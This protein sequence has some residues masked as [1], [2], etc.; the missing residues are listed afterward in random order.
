M[1]N[2]NNKMFAWYE[3][4]SEAIGQLPSIKDKYQMML[5]ITEYG[6]Y[7][8]EPRFIDT[9][10]CPAFA[11]Q[12]IFEACRVNLDNSRTNYKKGYQGASAGIKGGRPRKGE[13]AEEAYA[14]RNGTPKTSEPDQAPAP[15][16]A[17][18]MENVDAILA[19]A[20]KAHEQ[21]MLAGVSY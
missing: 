20:T 6:T 9:D 16:S 13:T 18:E 14:R 12:A 5:A 17:P 10:T 2:G 15:E 11:M 7:G 8:K 1:K 21:E 4:Y 19:E 3:S